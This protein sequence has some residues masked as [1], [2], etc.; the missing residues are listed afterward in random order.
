MASVRIVVASEH[1]STQEI[2]DRVG[3]RLC[4]RGHDVEVHTLCPGDAWFPPVGPLVIGSAVHDGAWLPEADHFVKKHAEEL[5][6]R[7]VWM[8]SVGMTAALPRPLRALAAR[9]EQPHIAGLVDLVH[10]REHH[11]FS[12]V[13]RRGHLSRKGAVLFRLLGCRYGDHRDWTEIDAW[14]AGIS[15]ALEVR[16]DLTE[17]SGLAQSMRSG[18][19]G[20]GDGPGER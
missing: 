19:R 20:P 8:Y 7:P 1:H 14:A 13:I 15:R 11:R 9:A 10:P 6:S 2:A 17:H 12:G 4:E 18:Q 5:G 16:P 3:T